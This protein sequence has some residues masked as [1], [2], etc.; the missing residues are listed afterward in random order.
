MNC[1]VCVRS[2]SK[3]FTALRRIS[4]W[5]RRH[6]TDCDGC[7]TVAIESNFAVLCTTATARRNTAWN[8]SYTRIRHSLFGVYVLLNVMRV[9]TRR[10]TSVFFRSH[11][12]IHICTKRKAHG[13]GRK[14]N[15]LHSV[16]RGSEDRFVRIRLNSGVRVDGCVYVTWFPHSLFAYRTQSQCALSHRHRDM[17]RL[18]WS[19]LRFDTFGAF[20]MRRASGVYVI[21][22]DFEFVVVRKRS[23]QSSHMQASHDSQCHSKQWLR[24]CGNFICFYSNRLELDACRIS[25]LWTEW[26]HD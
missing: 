9:E 20:W 23:E 14:R 19:F 6:S 12:A 15:N 1:A 4:L 22:V 7:D 24:W 3:S 17:L 26:I 2:I 10:R 11:A 8:Y 16:W 25:L 13:R 18:V 5:W 21:R